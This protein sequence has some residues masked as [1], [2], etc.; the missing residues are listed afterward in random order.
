MSIESCVEYGGQCVYT[1]PTYSGMCCCSFPSPPTPPPGGYNVVFANVNIFTNNV[2]TNVVN[3]VQWQINVS[4]SNCGTSQTGYGNQQ[5]IA[6]NIDGCGEV[7]L[8]IQPISTPSGVSCT[9]L[10]A[11]ATVQANQTA[12]L[13]LYC[14][15]ATPTV[16]GPSWSIVVNVNDPYNAGYIITDNYSSN[17]VLQAARSLS[18]ITFATYPSSVSSVTL[19]ASIQFNPPNMQCS[20]TPSTI[21]VNAPSGGTGSVTQNFTVTCSSTGASS[22]SSPITTPTTT[23][24]AT[25]PSLAPSARTL[26]TSPVALVALG[27]AAGV[28]IGLIVYGVSRRKK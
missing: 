4:P 27:V 14:T 13:A 20:I 6:I 21:T 24:T 16:T 25:T 1:P 3:Q 11:S 22:T 23:V 15:P 7:T 26:L 8:T 9:P 5:G 10:T 18:N 12:V 17:D 28:G 2:P 19:N